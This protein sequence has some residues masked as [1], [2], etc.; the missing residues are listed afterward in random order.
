MFKGCGL[1]IVSHPIIY[2]QASNY[3]Q[4][5]VFK[6]ILKDAYNICPKS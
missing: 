6:G 3:N 2:L 1:F 5:Y 4:E